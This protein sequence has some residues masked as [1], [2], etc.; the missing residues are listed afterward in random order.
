MNPSQV[1]LV[2]R[3]EVAVVA[4][5]P[6]MLLTPVAAVEVFGLGVL[7]ERLPSELQKVQT[8]GMFRPFTVDFWSVFA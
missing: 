2:G 4:R 6:E 7:G 1:G 5:A 3:R 8:L